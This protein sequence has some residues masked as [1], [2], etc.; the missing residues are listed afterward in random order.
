MT[1]DIR[2]EAPPTEV[3]CALRRACGWGDVAPVVAETSLR[4]SLINATIYV[5]GHLAGFGRVVGDGVLYFYIQ[6]VIIHQNF[7]GRGHATR[8]IEAL[9]RRILD[10]APAGSTIGLMAV[11]GRESMYERFGFVARPTES[12]GAGMTLFVGAVDQ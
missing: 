2:Y 3:F 6:D 4:R 10:C 1:V 5:D 9:M 7:R 11:R 8:L 12:Y